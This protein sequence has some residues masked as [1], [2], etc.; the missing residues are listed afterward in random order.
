MPLQVTALY[1]GLLGLIGIV[2][3]AL[4]GPVRD[5]T[6]ISLGDG[7][8]KELIE[9]GRRHMNWVES[10]PFIL[11]LFAIIEL[12]G[13]SRPW[14]HAMGLALVASRAMHPFGIDAATMRLW[15]R[16]A[17]AAGTFFVTIAATVTVL[18]QYLSRAM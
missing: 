9:A 3:W 7:G 8:N 15:P 18:W 10:V 12:N 2:L 5:R 16:I 17:G 14:L 6:N 1:A 13:G 11:V 4:V